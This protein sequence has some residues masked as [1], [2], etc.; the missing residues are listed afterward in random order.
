MVV[1]LCNLKPVK[2][3]GVLS[4]GMVMCASTPDKVEIL[5][6]PAGSQPGD[7]VEFPGFPRL[8]DPLLNP[9]KKI[10]ET[11]APDLMTNSDRAA[12]YKDAV[13]TVPGKG[14][15]I[16]PSLCGVAVK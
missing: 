11:C 6:P 1:V 7:L 3:R 4:C 10:F 12:V 15:V 14:A 5:S 13:M 2:M 16:A 8:P 9:K